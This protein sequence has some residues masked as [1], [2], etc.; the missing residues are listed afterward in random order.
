MRP[1]AF[2]DFIGATKMRLPVS[3]EKLIWEDLNRLVYIYTQIQRLADINS[4]D[5]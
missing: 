5:N 2:N 4:R 3:R 1:S